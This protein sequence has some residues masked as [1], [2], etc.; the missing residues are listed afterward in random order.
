MRLKI[1]ESQVRISGHKTKSFEG[2]QALI[3]T[4]VLLFCLRF[5]K[6]KPCFE[7]LALDIAVNTSFCKTLQ[8][9]V[10]FGLFGSLCAQVSCLC[11]TCQHIGE[12]GAFPEV[13][14]F[15]ADGIHLAQVL[16]IRSLRWQ[17]H[18]DREMFATQALTCF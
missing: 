11:I 13:F 6:D 15:D 10:Q 1:N 16:G 8:N 12:A 14:N 5:D 4:E 9:N 17:A 3:R 7:M 2:P 18:L